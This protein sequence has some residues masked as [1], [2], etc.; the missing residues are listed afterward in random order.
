[1]PADRFSIRPERPGDE[2]AIRTLTRV[3]F[4]GVPHGGGTEPGIVDALRKHGELRLSLIALDSDEIIGH[5]AFSPVAIDGNHD[6]WFGLGPIS[7]APDR[8]RQGV[9]SEL[10]QEG[11]AR[12]K[13]A[14]A[15]GCAL[16]GDPA[17]YNRFGFAGDSGLTYPGVEN[18]YVQQLAFDDVNRSGVLRFCDAFESVAG[19]QA[20]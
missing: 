20:E 3:A 6:C 18:R 7:V 16:V 19:G 14:G 1:M 15:K 4:A 5:A 11:L 2:D 8:Q 13:T 12:L 10:V 17:Y 9:G